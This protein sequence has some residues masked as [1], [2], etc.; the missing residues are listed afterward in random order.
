M[1]APMDVDSRR[2]F[3]ER[4]TNPWLSRADERGRAPRDCEEP[5]RPTRA[6][7]DQGIMVHCPA[8]DHAELP[9]MGSTISHCALATRLAAVLGSGGRK[10]V[11]NP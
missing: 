3:P 6:G 5:A 10:C 4:V 7:N 11:P 1:G 2:G 8:F 9:L